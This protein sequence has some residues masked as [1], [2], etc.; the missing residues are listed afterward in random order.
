MVAHFT[1]MAS[2]L[3]SLLQRI[4]RLDSGAPRFLLLLIVFALFRGLIYSTINPPLG[5]PDEPE[6]FRLVEFLATGGSNGSPGAYASHSHLYYY[7]LVP[8]YWL[9]SGQPSVVQQVALRP[10][11][12]L[13]LIGSILFTWLAA[14]KLAPNKPIVPVVAGIFITLHPQYGVISAS[15]NNDNAANLVSAVLT[16]LAVATIL[17]QASVRTALLT[18]TFIGL[19]LMTKGQ[20]LPLVAI[21]ALILLWS[22]LEQCM[23]RSRRSAILYLL[24]F[25]GMLAVLVAVGWGSPLL[26]RAQTVLSVLA[27]WQDILARAR[28]E[29]RW[30]FFYQYT[31]F[32]AAFLGESVRPPTICYAIPTTVV[33]LGFAGYLTKLTRDRTRFLFAQRQLVATLVLVA[34]LLAQWFTIY[35]YYSSTGLE[36]TYRIRSLQGRFLFPALPA[37]ALLVA[38]GWGHLVK[39]KNIKT[40]IV[41]LMILLLAFDI[42][43]LWALA[44]FYYWPPGS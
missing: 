16:Y 18:A 14:R 8:I 22:I 26:I 1:S 4:T 24:I 13:Y 11:S 5:S 32:W 25:V 23:M 44:G 40:A 19:A 41:L 36:D 6:H 20:T 28:Q 3:R 37:L 7:L 33:A 12:T 35:L 39:G 30:V 17:E 15:I 29:G 10:L 31:S 42:S 27:N 43:A 9:T 34:I 38:Q 2:Y 21:S